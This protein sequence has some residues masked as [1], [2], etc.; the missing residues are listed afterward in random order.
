MK[1]GKPVE[2]YHVFLSG[3]GGVGKSHVIRLIHSDTLRFLKLSATSLQPDGVAVLTDFHLKFNCIN[4]TSISD[5]NMSG[6]ETVRL[7]S[8]LK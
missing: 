8:T 7:E 2:P 1:Q 4:T 6:L 3:P 5:N